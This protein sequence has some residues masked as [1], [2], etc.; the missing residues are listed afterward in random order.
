[1]ASVLR[2][3]IKKIFSVLGFGDRSN[4]KET[5]NQLAGNYSGAKMFVAGYE[6]EAQFE[7]TANHTVDILERYAGIKPEDV[8]LE[9][10]CGVG[11]VG[12]VL[13]KRVTRW[14]GTDISGNM[15]AY[16]AQRL[17]GFENIELK[18]LS[19]VG[20]KEIPDQSID[21]VYCTVVFMHL[22]EWDRYRYVAESFRVLKTGGRCF[23]DNVDII[24]DHGWEVF[25]AG[26]AYAAEARPPQLSMTSS[27]DELKTYA[28]KAG[29]QNIRIHRWDN[30]WVGVTGVK[31]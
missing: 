23:F 31:P 19:T 17:K 4:Y 14:I 29:F 11:R 10:G 9:I 8:V 6:D 16:A 25:S 12:K 27:G 2:T 24:S 3:K 1:M 21:L 28:E 30:A 20:L 18:E 26:Y 5:W 7:L 13:S 22:L 15:L